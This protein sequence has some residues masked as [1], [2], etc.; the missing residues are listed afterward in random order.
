M[1]K[2]RTFSSLLRG[3]VA[4]AALCSTLARSPDLRS[5]ALFARSFRSA[6]RLASESSTSTFWRRTQSMGGSFRIT[7]PTRTMF[8][9][10]N[11]A[12]STSAWRSRGRCAIVWASARRWL[13]TA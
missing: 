10:L 8:A 12:L 6:R 3:T 13:S 9:L 2:R 4:P 11:R 7:S 5:D 1:G